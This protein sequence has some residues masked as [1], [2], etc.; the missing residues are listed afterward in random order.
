MA[1]KAGFIIMAPDGDPV[2]HRSSIKTSKLE[3]TTVVVNFSDFE[4]TVG[5]CRELVNEKGVQA[6]YLC[7]YFN[8]K[9]V[10]QI[11]DSVGEKV[12]IIVAM[13]DVPGMM[14]MSAIFQKEGWALDRHY[15][16]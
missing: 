15:S 9:E 6:L 7:G 11:A 4:K 2:K 3:V 16:L 13:S 12:P 14:K 10:A 5:V 1:L 8:Q